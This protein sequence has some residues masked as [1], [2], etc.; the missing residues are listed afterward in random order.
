M[1]KGWPVTASNGTVFW[2]SYQDLKRVQSRR[3]YHENSNGYHRIR[4]LNQNRKWIELSRFI[5]GVADPKILVDHVNHDRLDNR[6]SNLRLATKS[7]NQFNQRAIRGR[8]PFKGVREAD[9]GFVAT[10]SANHQKHYLGYFRSA[11]EA[12]KAY[13]K[14]AVELHGE[15]A[16][17]NG[18]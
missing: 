18:V 5:L 15:F 8:V 3:W 2:V 4:C 6:R 1:D 12:A 14:A 11:V 17:I 10:I 7:E 16:K 13:D 9:G